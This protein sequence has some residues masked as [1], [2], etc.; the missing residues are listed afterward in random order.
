MEPAL[1]SNLTKRLSKPHFID[2]LKS[3]SNQSFNKGYFKS[4]KVDH[5][6]SLFS[7]VIIGSLYYVRQ[8]PTNCMNT[9]S[10]NV[11]LFIQA[12]QTLKII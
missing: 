7:Q 1:T 4:N 5:M 2:Y 9:L 11:Q 3:L 6:F 10:K 8:E 12:I